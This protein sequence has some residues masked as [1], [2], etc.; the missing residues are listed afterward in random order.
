[1]AT[2]TINPE[3]LRWAISESGL[4]VQELSERVDADVEAWLKRKAKPSVTEL[5]NVAKELKRPFATF[6]LP[7]PPALEAPAVQFRHSP[8]DPRNSLNPDERKSI[9]EATRQQRVLSWLVEQLEGTTVEM[10]S[11]TLETSPDSAARALREWVG[12]AGDTQ[13]KWSSSATALRGWR[14]ALEDHG[15]AVFS[16]PMGS[17]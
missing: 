12:V 16:F 13:L 7:A 10:P 17:A 6:F 5:R 2:L 9:R 14:A 3:V 1:M 11:F 15:V 8:D 4:T